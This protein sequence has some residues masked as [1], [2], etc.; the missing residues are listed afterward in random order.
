MGEKL[1]DMKDRMRRPIKSN[2]NSRR[3]KRTKVV[4]DEIMAEYIQK[5]L[6]DMNYTIPEGQKIWQEK[7]E[8][9]V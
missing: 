7:K 1:I 6:Y 9:Y 3:E 4:F 8:T 5:L 2:A